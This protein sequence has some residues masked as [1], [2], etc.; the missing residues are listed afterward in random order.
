MWMPCLSW[1]MEAFKVSLRF[2]FPS[3]NPRFGALEP[4]FTSFLLIFS[5]LKPQV[6]VSFEKHFVPRLLRGG[7]RCFAVSFFAKHRGAEP[8][9]GLDY[10]LLGI[11]TPKAPGHLRQGRI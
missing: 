7:H 1:A 5:T 6:D 4:Y 3:S 2:Q 8:V 9:V 10:W 11:C